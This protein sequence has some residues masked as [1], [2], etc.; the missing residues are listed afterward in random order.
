MGTLGFGVDIGGTGIKGAP[1]DLVTGKLTEK[2]LRILTPHPATP[3]AVALTVNELVQ[4]FEWKGSIGCTFPAVIANGVARTAS[5]V[6]ATWVDTSVSDVMASAT[7]C[8]TVVANDADAAG[9]AEVVFGAA[10]GVAGL[11]VVVTLGTGIGTALIFN[12]Q[13]V[14]NSE[15]GHLKLHDVDAETT[16]SALARERDGLTYEQWAKRLQ[17]YFSA[18][19][20]LLW[21]TLFV[22]GGGESKHAKHFLPLLDLRTPIVPAT[23]RNEAGIIGAALLSASDSPPGPGSDSPPGP[24][25]DIPPGPGPEPSVTPPGTAGG[26]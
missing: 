16:T 17:R 2:R 1:V 6:D 14:P 8:K 22:V 20:E 5:N 11:V 12:G 24:G 13:L 15:F 4:H 10:K 7:G 25:P 26:A 18:L 19:E 21:P 9:L 23:L 3:D